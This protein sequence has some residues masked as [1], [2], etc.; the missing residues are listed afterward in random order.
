MRSPLN[1]SKC[2]KNIYVCFTSN[3]SSNLEIAKKIRCD[4]ISSRIILD[5]NTNFFCS[6]F[7]FYI[8]LGEYVWTTVTQLN[9]PK[10]NSDDD[11]VGDKTSFGRGNT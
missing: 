5:I 10:C 1:S 8:C 7:L 6:Q 3:I 9:R 11:G 2:D 4:D